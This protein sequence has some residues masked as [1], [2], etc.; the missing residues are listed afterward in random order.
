MFDIGFSELSLLAVL[1]LLILGPERLPGV[2]RVLG[3]YLRKARRTWNTVK[4]EIE[5]ELA[6]SEI[7]NTI[8]QPLEELD[9]LRQA[10][11]D[12]VDLDPVAD[13][14]IKPKEQNQTDP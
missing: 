1:G 7:R 3:G 6:V 8:K 14:E 9:E 11:S 12:L 4:A 13:P 10:A 2:A 5:S